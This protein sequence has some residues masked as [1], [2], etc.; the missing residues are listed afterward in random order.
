MSANDSLV[1]VPTKCHTCDKDMKV[2]EVNMCCSIC[3]ALVHLSCAFTKQ[4]TKDI[5]E[6]IKGSELITFTCEFCKNNA[7]RIKKM[8]DENKE[9]MDQAKKSLKI[10]N[11]E[12]VKKL[13]AFMKEIRNEVIEMNKKIADAVHNKFETELKKIEFNNDEVNKIL[14]ELVLDKSLTNKAV[15]ETNEMS[16]KLERK[17]Q[18]IENSASK[19]K[20][21]VWTLVSGDKK[22]K[23]KENDFPVILNIKDQKSYPDLKAA[24][25][26]EIHPYEVGIKNVIKTKNNKAVI[27][28]EDKEN[29]EKLKVIVE[30]K[31]SEIASASTPATKNPRVKILNAEIWCKFEEINHE[32]IIEA[33]KRENAALE[34]AKV[35]KVIKILNVR[36]NGLV[37]EG[38]VNIVLE[39]DQ[40]TYRVIM[41]EE[42]VKY[43]FCT[44]R[45]IDGISVNRCYKC[46][47][48][49][50]SVKMC[51]N[52]EK[53]C[54]K[55]GGLHLEKECSNGEPCCINCKRANDSGAKYDTKHRVTDIKCPCYEK[56]YNRVSR[57][58]VL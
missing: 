20:E 28:C 40:I 57:N 47:A 4:C 8:I 14:N 52:S 43:Q 19:I 7:D 51:T 30:N 17:A 1:Y 46:F 53:M 24:M 55:C 35:L 15:L 50:H 33:L 56:A 54:R 32:K 6:F 29:Q 48:F 49:N 38:K 31:L 10:D 45:V 34:H 3:H 2:N 37:I 27:F 42:K 39:V 22:K 9:I 16:K 5:Y 41:T 58:I 13:D 44:L 23:R 36:R 12:L 11:K 25:C 26:E 18:E 21:N